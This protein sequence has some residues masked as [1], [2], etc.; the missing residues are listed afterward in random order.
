MVVAGT[1]DDQA[2]DGLELRRRDALREEV[3]H[4]GGHDKRP[5]HR[6][7]L[8]VLRDL[9]A[10]GARHH[11]GNATARKG[12]KRTEQKNVERRQR[13]GSADTGVFVE[14]LRGDRRSGGIQQLLL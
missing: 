10:A 5:R 2:V 1:A 12:S 4:D 7:P 8:E 13:Q 11:H 14:A 6:I 9:G 3:V